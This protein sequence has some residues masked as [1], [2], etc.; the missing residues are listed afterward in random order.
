MIGQ[1]VSHY[2]IVEKLGA[3]AMGVVYIAEDMVL[4][5]RVA[6]KTLTAARDSPD[7]HFRARFLREARSISKLSHPHIATIHDYGETED[8]QPY[9]VMEL[10]QGETLS[11]LRARE[12]LTIRRVI[13]IIEQVADALSEAHRHGIIH[14]DIKPS[15]IAIGERGE[16]K[17]LDFGL[18]KEIRRADIKSKSP[19]FLNT[20]TREG[21]VV[22]T[23]QYLSPE[24]ALGSEVDERSDLFT[25]GSVLYECIA[26]YP[27]FPG[28]DP[29]EICSKIIR[30]VPPPP[31]VF[32]KE[33]PR[34]LD[35]ITL[36]ALE[37]KPADRYQTAAELIEDLRGLRSVLDR[38]GS[39]QTV[40]RLITR[41]T[42]EHPTGAIATL[43]DIFRRPRLS[44][45]V[46]VLTVAMIPLAAWVLIAAFKPRPHQPS[47]EAQKWYK[48]GSE[49]L[50]EGAYF[51]AIK[52]LQQA[53]STDDNF[54]LAHARLAEAW[55]EL[56]YTER[57]QLELLRVHGLVPD[58]SS[59]EEAD[60][61]YLDAIRATIMRDFNLAIS[62]YEKLAKLKPDEA[63]PY[64]DLGRAYEKNDQIDK[65]IENFNLAI[66]RDAQY[67]PA[68]LH[69]GT[70][71]GRKQDLTNANA[72]FDKADSLFQISGDFEG[73][74]EVLYQRGALLNKVGK[75]AEAQDQLEY[76][77]EI[78]KTSN[79]EHQQIKT[80]LE[81][82]SVMYLRGN[83][84]QAKERAN[85][86][87]TLAQNLEIENLATQG[88]IDLGNLYIVRREYSEA[89]HVLTQALEFAKRNKGR[90]NA[91]RSQLTLAKLYLQQEIKTDEA[92]G[93]LEQALTY[94]QEGGY[95][96]EVSDVIL[97]RA[98]AKLLKGDYNGSLKDFEQQLKFVQETQN[99]SQLA[100]TL[101]LI[102]NA[103]EGL[104][105]YPEALTSFKKSYDIFKSLGVPLTVGYLLVDQSEM[106]WRIGKSSDALSTLNEVGEVANRVDSNYR[107]VLNA[108]ANL[109][110]SQVALTEGNIAEARSAAEQSLKLSGT[111]VN[112]TAVEAKCHL[113]LVQARSG[114]ASAG[115]ASSAQAVEW[116]KQ[117]NDEHLLSLTM[118][119]HAETLLENGQAKEALAEALQAQTR[120]KQAGQQ[121]SEWQAWF[122]AGRASLKLSDHADA[123][124]R[125]DRSLAT[126]SS[127]EQ[128]WGSEAFNTYIN[129]PDVRTWRKELEQSNAAAR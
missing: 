53:V 60:G 73:R 105:R 41:S 126:L 80:M 43:S 110:R 36:K 129:R 17:V 87:V 70:I 102:G 48:I 61:L 63:Q 6:I 95:N 37:K 22:G 101:L 77:L 54:A 9:I 28:I 10:V 66:R 99:H 11:E 20:Q 120:F 25:L 82:S 51:K 16:V 55:T 23:P 104:E 7:H 26:G 113:G 78:A 92:L 5:R 42:S 109:V 18:A 45:G 86:A 72:A 71:Y 38:K 112:H 103:L 59:L 27:A 76:A 127:L 49:N 115:S 81:M 62:S 14:R 50:R 19:E 35:R 47:A 98:Q 89:E 108:R 107:E 21:V 46:V 119:A 116:A 3:G 2:R 90:R 39:E 44:V 68:Y 79:N 58:R 32:N 15:N 91:A 24:Q 30:E 122:I 125:F 56:D 13:E 121:E 85:S 93:Y 31:S 106:L 67:S 52:P 74:T 118:L 69:L 111:K 57:A 1:T 96:K 117:L 12:A 40:T 114:A 100:K 65:A 123:R 75:L 88:L 128:T 4:D 83:T 8:G 124:E 34:E 84:Q 29:F 97:S 64:F 94:F 33:I